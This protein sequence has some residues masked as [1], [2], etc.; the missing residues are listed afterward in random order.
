MLDG[1]RSDRD[2]VAERWGS[3]TSDSEAFSRAVYWLAI[4]EVFERYQRK[5]TGGRRGT[6]VE[7]VLGEVF[8]G[9]LP[10]ARI[11]SLGCGDGS[12]ERQLASLDAFKRCEAWDLS[13]GAIE[14]ARRNAAA[15]GIGSIDYAVADLNRIRLARSVYDAVW[16]NGSLHHVEALE[17]V[18]A[19]VAGAL[20]P[21]GVVVAHEYAG[22]SR[23]DFSARQKALIEAAFQLIPERLRRRF[24]GRPD[25]AP[26]IPDPSKV[27]E[28]DPSE[29]VRSAEIPAVLE[30]YFDIVL[31]REAG[32]ALL[33]F[34]LA[35]IAGNFRSGEKAEMAVLR[36]LFEIEDSLM[37][38]GDLG[39]D[40][41][42]M[43]GRRRVA[44]YSAELALATSTANT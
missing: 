38:A 8:E 31:R 21:G 16:F 41:V 32:G 28:A 7:S 15:A 24:D 37:E 36:M 39:S 25:H 35:G 2:V 18:C 23:F 44:D 12:L 20:K 9:R 19:E 34:L 27:R 29:A 10:L 4:P 40:F 43:V 17:H 3:L 1:P 5:L 11:L 33:H 42:L 30:R 14:A 6:W 26:F 13:P 22:A